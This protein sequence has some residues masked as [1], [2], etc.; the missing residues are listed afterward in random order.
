MLPCLNFHEMSLWKVLC[1]T[2]PLGGRW[3]AVD[4]V[5]SEA[6]QQEIISQWRSIVITLF[7][8]PSKI[9]QIFVFAANPDAL[10]ETEHCGR[11]FPW[12]YQD[13]HEA[14]VSL[15]WSVPQLG[16]GRFS[17]CQ[18]NFGLELCRQLFPLSNIDWQKSILYFFFFNDL[19][20]GLLSFF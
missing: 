1:K 3:P 2:R 8:L 13:V 11:P 9:H 15:L 10:C 12:L 5:V 19:F 7:P 14:D 4:L 17:L 6:A 20:Y 16:C 18:R